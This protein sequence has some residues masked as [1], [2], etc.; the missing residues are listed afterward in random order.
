MSVDIDGTKSYREDKEQPQLSMLV[1]VN[2][3]SGQKDSSLWEFTTNNG[4]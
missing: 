3:R 2:F 4:V 1:R